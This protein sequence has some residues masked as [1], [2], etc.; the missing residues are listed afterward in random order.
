MKIRTIALA[1]GALSLM[2]SPAIAEA[3]FERA[4]AP[5]EGESELEGNASYLFA[6]LGAAAVVGGIIV[7][8]SNDDDTPTS[9]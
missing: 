7:A 6:I 1:A 8:S 3:A 5:L 2:A 4:S 9:P